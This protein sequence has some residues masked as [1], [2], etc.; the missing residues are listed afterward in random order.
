MQKYKLIKYLG[1]GD[2]SDILKFLKTTRK[3]IIHRKGFKH[4]TIDEQLY[5]TIIESGIS[6]FLPNYIIKNF[7][8]IKFEEYLLGPIICSGCGSKIHKSSIFNT[9]IHFVKHRRAVC[10]EV[11]DKLR[12]SNQMLGLKNCYH[13]LTRTQQINLHKQHS[14]SMKIA[15]HE[16][17]FTPTITNSWAK[18][19]RQVLINGIIKKVRSSWEAYFYICNPNLEY[20]ALRIPYQYNGKF[21]VYILDFVDLINRII[22]EIKPSC[23][24]TSNLNLVKELAARDW[25]KLNNFSYKNISNDWFIE[26]YN[27][28]LLIGQ[29]DLAEIERLL[30]QFNKSN[31]T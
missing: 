20:E 6:S 1:S 22:Y 16:G 23:L 13:K 8:A 26:N 4:L 29:P 15:I 24:K 28:S 10:S 27:P 7:T 25:A 18:S 14:E 30:K 11:C 3:F 5:R 12:K 2:H 9:Q 21:H 19:R 17:R 31:E